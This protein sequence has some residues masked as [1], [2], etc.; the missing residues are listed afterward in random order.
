MVIMLEE[1]DHPIDGNFGDDAGVAGGEA[2]ASNPDDKSK[3]I[4]RDIEFGYDFHSTEEY[5]L[6]NA[7]FGNAEAVFKLLEYKDSKEIELDINCKGKHKS[8][9]GWTPLHLASYFGHAKVAEMLLEKGANANALNEQGDTPIHKASYTGRLDIVTLLLSYNADVFVK[10]DEGQTPRVLAQDKNIGDLL[11]AAEEADMMKL[12]E[13]FFSAARHGDVKTLSHLLNDPNKPIDINHQDYNGNSALHWS[14]QRN[15]QEAVVFLLQSA[16]NVNLRNHKN[17]LAVSLAP[18][19]KMKQLLQDI[20]PVEMKSCTGTGLQRFEGPL[21]RKTKFLGWRAVWGVIERGVLSFYSSRADAAIG[22]RQR[23][24]KYLESSRVEACEK[25]VTMFIIF[26]SDKS[27]VILC[28]PPTSTTLS[29]QMI[30]RQRWINAVNEHIEYSTNFLRQGLGLD[31]EEEDE[32]QELIAVSSMQPILQTA[33]AHQV[34]LDKHIKELF[35]MV[36]HDIQSFGAKLIGKSQ[37]YDATAESSEFW[38]TI[39]SHL[40]VILESSANTSS[41]LSQAMTVLSNQDQLRQ[42]QLKQEKDKVRVLEEALSVLAREHHEMEQSMVSGVPYHSPPRPMSIYSRDSEDEYYDA[43]ADESEKEDEG[44]TRAEEV[45]EDGGNQVENPANGTPP[46]APVVKFGLYDDENMKGRTKLPS[47]VPS[48]NDA[49][50]WSVLRNCIGKEL[51]K[52]ALPVVFNEPLTFL[53]RIVENSAFVYLLKEADSCDD[54]IKRMEL[55][56]SYAVA[57]M[58]PNWQRLM[59]PFNPILGETFELTVDEYDY[60]VVCEQVSHHPPVSAL[61]GESEHFEMY[62]T[63]QPRLKFWGKSIDIKPE[64]SLFV[65]LKKR[66]ETYS[67]KAVN[68]CIHNVIIGKLW[69]EQYGVMEIINNSIGLRSSINFKAAGWFGRD[70]H[71]VEGFVYANDK[72]TKL[73]FLYGKW[74][75]YLKSATVEDY[76]DYMRQQELKL[77]PDKAAQETSSANRVFSKFNSFT[78]GVIG[79]SA[80]AST[81]KP[82]AYGPE[83]PS[84]DSTFSLDIPNSSLL[85]KATPK[86]SYSEEYYGMS[87]FSMRL[88]EL[89][90]EMR[91]TLAPTDSRYRPDVRFLEEG[92]IDLAATEKNRLEEKQREA[93]KLRKQNKEDWTPLW[94]SLKPNPHI[95]QNLWSYNGGYWNRDFSSSPDLF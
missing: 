64:G 15:K 94:F 54:P 66:N 56:T 73:R 34:L 20:R 50:I 52:I 88:N 35:H 8:N 51:S 83:I 65:R 25:D 86:P 27:K 62:G 49:N 29:N 89:T 92:Q 26:F 75:E 57:T 10:N 80:P 84:S 67:W 17:Q 24:Y 12:E 48:R 79:T 76:E 81:E 71:R 82:D 72:S 13:R 39:K 45:T 21:L 68:C 41:A 46:T 61:F 31:D 14:A 55:V 19:L 87:L 47:P 16:I 7:R 58:S 2:T 43:F 59:K 33:Q 90:S 22:R 53:Q 63:V 70:L 95:K 37:F 23:N 91:K 32:L 4:L 1:D 6:Y 11:L 78:K 5:L 74:T 93:R 18:T 30:D 28:T 77:Q 3:L 9:F 85:W 38:S 60:R 40:T 42:L 36:E 69:I 44:H